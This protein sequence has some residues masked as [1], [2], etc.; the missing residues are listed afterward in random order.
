[1]FAHFCDMKGE[2]ALA[3]TILGIDMGTKN[4]KISARGGKSIICEKNV[5]AME[6][7][8]LYSFGDDAYEMFEKAPDNITVSFPVKSGV[9]ADYRDMRDILVSFI[10]KYFK[11]G[12]KGATVIV[13]VP[14]D[15]AVILPLLLTVATLVLD[16]ENVAP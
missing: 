2:K 13:A 6:G 5:I 12:I 8:L 11:G 15:L 3:S 14:D 7:S 16:E 10:N 4:I 1:M 9:I